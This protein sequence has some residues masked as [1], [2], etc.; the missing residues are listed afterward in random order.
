MDFEQ[1]LELSPGSSARGGNRADIADAD[2][3]VVT[4]AVPL[5]LNSSRLVYLADNAKSACRSS[6]E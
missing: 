4:A 1:V 5:T 6:T 3:V 2:V